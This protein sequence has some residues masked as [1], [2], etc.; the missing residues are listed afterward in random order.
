V[1]LTL[2]VA[3]SAGLR[4]RNAR[5]VVRHSRPLNDPASSRMPLRRTRN[6]VTPES[7]RSPA[8]MRSRA[9]AALPWFALIRGT[10]PTSSDG[11]SCPRSRHLQGSR[12]FK[13]TYLL[14]H[15]P[16]S[17][18]SQKLL[19]PERARHLALCA[20]TNGGVAGR[21]EPGAS[22]ASPLACTAATTRRP[23]RRL[24]RAPSRPEPAHRE[25]TTIGIN[26]RRPICSPAGAS[27]LETMHRPGSSLTSSGW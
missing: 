6:P 21:A 20:N 13:G 8:S 10:T 1:L 2:R 4:K 19:G 25:T 12:R 7:S 3:V 23:R 18:R 16:R 26:R 5:S 15:E 14:G 11:R 17:L 27:T 22:R 24:L 9:H